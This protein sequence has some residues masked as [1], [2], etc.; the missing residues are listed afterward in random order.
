V[1]Q[2]KEFASAERE[3]VSHLKKVCHYAGHRS[4][5]SKY[6]LAI[7]HVVITP[8]LTDAEALMESPIFIS[9]GEEPRRIHKV[10]SYGPCQVYSKKRIC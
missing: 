2:G 6:L 1:G 10:F 5:F 9:F 7:E 4:R 8:K 3:K